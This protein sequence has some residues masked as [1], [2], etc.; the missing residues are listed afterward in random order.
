[1]EQNTA[2]II[3]IILLSF[4]LIISLSGI[5]ILQDIVNVFVYA[6]S[7]VWN[8]VKIFLQNLSNS[9]GEVVNGTTDVAVD[10]SIF[11]I[12]II[13]GILHDIGNMFRGQATP[14]VVHNIDKHIQNHKKES[15]NEPEPEPAKQNDKEKWCLAGVD[16]KGKNKCVKLNANQKCNSQ[17]IF[18][19]L[20]DCN[21]HHL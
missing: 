17:K 18:D 14:V 13:D 19:S 21:G 12:E 3:I 16:D 2:N 7:V 1:M 20:M 5:N 4:L 10:T 8:F 11:G 9:T 6:F 15:K